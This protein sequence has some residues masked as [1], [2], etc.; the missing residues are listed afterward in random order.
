MEQPRGENSGLW[1]PARFNGLSRL[2][3]AVQILSTVFLAWIVPANS[4]F[5]MGPN[6]KLGA[7]FV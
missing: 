2:F 4:L 6:I 1:K 5:R 3:C 7:G